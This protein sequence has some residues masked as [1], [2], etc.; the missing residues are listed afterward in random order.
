[1]LSRD[2]HGSDC[3]GYLRLTEE[4]EPCPSAVTAWS[5]PRMRLYAGQAQSVGGL[6][7]LP[8]FLTPTSGESDR[9][10]VSEEEV[11]SGPQ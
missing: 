6:G 7:G 1:M 9:L 2:G 5:P 10:K 3:Q 4:A 11:N 8:G